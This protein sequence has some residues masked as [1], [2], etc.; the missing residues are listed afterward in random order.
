MKRFGIVAL[1]IVVALLAGWLAAWLV[2]RQWSAKRIIGTMFVLR[3]NARSFDAAVTQ[4]A[5]KV[6]APE[7]YVRRVVGPEAYAAPKTCQKRNP[8]KTLNQV[9]GM[10][11]GAILSLIPVTAPA[12]AAVLAAATAINAAL[13]PTVVRAGDKCP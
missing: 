4:T 9:F 1:A 13:P 3:A 12:G 2:Q 5:A 7:W 10:V 11:G 8:A 6:G